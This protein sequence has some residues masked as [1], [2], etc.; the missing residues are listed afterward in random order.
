MS[1]VKPKGLKFKKKRMDI[2]AFIEDEL[3]N[4]NSVGGE[5]PKPMLSKS[6]LKTKKKNPVLIKPSFATN[7]IKKRD[8]V[9]REPLLLSDPE[10]EVK[11][12]PAMKRMPDMPSGMNERR[13][14]RPFEQPLEEPSE[15]FKRP[16][17]PSKL[18]ELQ[19]R[20]KNRKFEEPL[21][22]DSKNGS[23][24]DDSFEKY[25]DDEFES[26]DDK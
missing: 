14:M 16:Q 6:G 23:D 4:L 19:S 21:P 17:G 9:E 1:K 22:V 7:M 24:Y 15:K 5:K 8:N 11:P 25:D 10:P 20:A 12:K 13:P 26:D 2:D 3:N 18:L